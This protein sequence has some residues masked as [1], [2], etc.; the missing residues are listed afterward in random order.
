[1]KPGFAIAALL[2]LTLS[3]CAQPVDTIYLWPGEVPFETKS[4][5]DPVMVTDE[6]DNITRITEITNPFLLVYKPAPVKNNGVG[7]VICPGGGYSILAIDLE[8]YE[9]A[10]W[11]SN[12]GYTVFVL[13]YRVPNNQAGALADAQR[14]LRLIR[15]RAREWSLN[16]DKLGVLGFSAGGSLAARLSTQYM[17]ANYQA[18]DRVD[19]LSSR[20]DFGMLIYPAYLDK[21]EDRSLTPEL[22][23]NAETPPMFIFATA[24]DPYSN[25]ALVMATALRDQ[26]VPVELH[27]LPFGG[28]GYGIRTGKDAAEIWP[29]LAESWLTRTITQ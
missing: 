12:R 1:M 19:S 10:E 5:A 26:E 8:G 25:S 9:I 4:K 27:L 6:G 24:D 18:V 7:I 11:L 23:V 20:P 28:H 21:G 14:A 22:L 2:L 13:N 15:S 3:N 29:K 16:P 17:A